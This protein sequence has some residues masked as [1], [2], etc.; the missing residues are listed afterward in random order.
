MVSKSSKIVF[1]LGKNRIPWARLYVSPSRDNGFHFGY[2]EPDF[3]NIH[4]TVFEKNGKV[5]S[6]ICDDTAK[7]KVS[8]YPWDQ[9]ITPDLLNDHLDRITKRW[10]MRMDGRTRCYVMTPFLLK[11]IERISPSIAKDGA[12]Q[13]PMEFIIARVELDFQNRRRWIRIALRDLSKTPP[14]RGY[15]I[16]NRHTVKMVIPAEE[17]RYLCF[18]PRQYD[19]LQNERFR[20]LGFQMYCDYIMLKHGQLVSSIVEKKMR[21]GIL[22]EALGE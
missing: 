14:Y 2:A 19:R 10:I 1:C 3:P 15:V 18:G 21:S 17:G 22:E 16:L 8:K 12:L 7:D 6:H 9:H 20:L 5:C 11:K 13:V 4:L